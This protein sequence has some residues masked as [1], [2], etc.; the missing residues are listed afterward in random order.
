MDIRD[1]A[2]E[3]YFARHEFT[4]PHQLSA[5]DCESLT[6][7]EVLELAGEA[8][9][10]LL[11]LSLG[12]TESR[13][14]PALRQVIAGFYPGCDPDD[15]LVTNAPEEAIFLAMHGLLASGDRVVVQTPC[16]QSLAEIARA[17]GCRVDPWPL[18]ED[19]GAWRADLDELA[20]L[21]PGARLLV[22]NTPHNPTGHHFAPDTYQ[23]LLALSQDH[24]VRVFCDEMYR[25]LESAP[26]QA[27]TPFASLDAR[28]LSLWG[29][30]KTFGLPGLRIGWLVCR[31]R[32]LYDR[33]VSLKDYTTICSSAP[34]EFL[35]RLGLRCYEPIARRNRERIAENRRAVAGFMDRHGTRMSW[36]PP[37]AGPVALARVNCIK[38]TDFCR[39][40]REGANV[41]L[42][43]S[44]LFGLDDRHVRLGLGRAGFASALSRLEHWLQDDHGTA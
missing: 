28:A 16:Y 14:D 13:G 36:A 4:V 20:E 44:A 25:G 37:T 43:P 27:L 23:R 10:R 22:I 7:G 29:M 11:A 34:G 35:A 8:P 17:I 2:L 31:D 15:V 39:M 33:L 3:R 24:G 38:A 41:L 26:E 32:E 1:F 12:Y 5:S 30:S 21:L 40:A 19:G 9:E 42:V 6:V 18:R